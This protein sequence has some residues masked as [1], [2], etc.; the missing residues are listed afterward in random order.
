MSKKRHGHHGGAWKV[1]YADFV[2]AMM[3]LFL[4][5]WLVSQDQKIKD[6]VQRAFTHPFSSM[7][8]GT[9][10]ILPKKPEVAAAQVETR[11]G[12]FDSASVVE[13]NAL[14]NI[15][16]ELLKSLQDKDNDL[17]NTMQLDLSPEGLRINLFDR[18]ARPL[19]NPADADFTEYGN[20]ILTT[21]AWQLARYPTYAIEIEGH[22]ERNAPTTRDDYGP[23][24]LSSDRANAARRKLITNGV[25]TQQIRKIAGF[26]D[27]SPIPQTA[28]DAESNRRVTILLK[29]TSPKR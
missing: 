12:N 4:V 18:A 6:A 3:A 14:R 13:L 23:W 20:W 28:P 21:L 9:T 16:Q 11:V 15:S 27:T 22:T 5:L 25:P 2:T 17:N 7:T 10:G 24:E 29:V 19:F 1:A 26:S 8:E